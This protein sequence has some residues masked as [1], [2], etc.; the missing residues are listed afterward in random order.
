[1][2]KTSNLSTQSY[3]NANNCFPKESY[4]RLSLLLFA[5]LGDL[6]ASLESRGASDA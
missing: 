4:Y 3:K 1:M 6:D 5:R 2:T